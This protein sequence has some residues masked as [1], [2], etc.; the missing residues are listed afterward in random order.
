MFTFLSKVV[1]ITIFDRKYC[2]IKKVL[3]IINMDMALGCAQFK[4]CVTSA[5]NVTR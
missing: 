1:I 3:T 4:I 2:F 5:K